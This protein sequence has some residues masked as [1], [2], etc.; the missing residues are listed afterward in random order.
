MTAAERVRLRR[1][2][3]EVS[4]GWRDAARRRCAARD[5]GDLVEEARAERSLEAGF[6][7]RD[8]LLARLAELEHAPVDEDGAVVRPSQA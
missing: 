5:T 7:T 4:E 2:L 8:E 6:R 3:A 1:Q